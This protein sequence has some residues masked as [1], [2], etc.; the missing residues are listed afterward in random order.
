MLLKRTLSKRKPAIIINTRP[1]CL[2]NT[3][4]YIVFCCFTKWKT[5]F[6]AKT[7]VAETSWWFAFAPHS[8]AVVRWIGS[9]IQI[10]E[11][12]RPNIREK[13]DCNRS[14]GS[15]LCMWLGLSLRWT[16][17]PT[18]SWDWRWPYCPLLVIFVVNRFE[19]I[20]THHTPDVAPACP[21]AVIRHDST[22]G[23]V[24]VHLL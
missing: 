16:F 13:L 24:V 8:H 2:H 22:S 7:K 18:V 1:F 10:S 9:L 15:W 12:L 23:M 4:F 17:R 20:R 6:W 11:G 14:C 5:L 3:T 19:P 21:Q